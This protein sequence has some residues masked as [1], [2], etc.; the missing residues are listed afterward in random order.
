[1]RAVELIE[2]FYR[3]RE[4]GDPHRLRRFLADDVIWREPEVGDHMGELR[5]PDAVI[6]MMVRAS[7]ATGGTFSLKVAEA[8]EVTGHCS[9]VVEWTAVKNGQMLSGRELAVFSVTNDQISAALFLPENLAH[10]REFWSEG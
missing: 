9:V 4:L 3:E 10:D 6:D 1:M 2:S 8:I 7:A 5:G